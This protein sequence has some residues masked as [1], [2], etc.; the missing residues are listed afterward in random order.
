MKRM[1]AT[2]LLIFSLP[3]VAS[4]SIGGWGSPAGLSGKP[5]IPEQESYA[6]ITENPFVVARTTP[7]S[8][9]GIDVDTASYSNVRRFLQGHRLPPVEAVRIEEM[10][11]S[12]A[13]GYADPSDGR[14][15]ALHTELS[16]CPWNK[17]H[18]LL[19]VGL[20]AKHLQASQIPPRNLVFLLDVSGSMSG[21]DKLPLMKTAMKKVVDQLRPE[22]SVAIVT[23]ATD[24]IVRLAPRKVTDKGVILRC[25]DSLQASGS[26]NGSG[27]IQM[28]YQLAQKNFD[29]K[30]VNRVIL[31]TDGDFNVGVVSI[32]ALQ[33]LIAEKR[34]TG[35]FL[36]VVGLGTG[37]LK[38]AT[39]EMLADRGN[40]RY[41]YLDSS[42][43]ARKA[44]G[45]ELGAD[46]VTVAKDVKV[47]IEFNPA[48]VHSYRLIGYENRALQARDF[49]DDHK[50]AGE[51]GAGHSVTALY[52]IVRS[53]ESGVDALR[54]QPDKKPAQT[55][56]PHSGEVCLVKIRYKEPA[57]SV[58]QRM[59][60]IVE[61]SAR[62]PATRDMRF[63]S[64]VAGFGLLLRQS[65]HKGEADYKMIK[66]LAK[67]SLGPDE[68]GDR[69]EFV[70]LVE[71]AEDMPQS[72]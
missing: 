2:W 50:D 15:I 11:N 18:E 61:A 33:T 31:A 23:Y 56:V 72:Q 51:M 36:T 30:G 25:I 54:Y 21:R 7:L 47:Q 5:P 52:E 29:A 68:N 16:D 63:A 70:R 9:F 58:S 14:A 42:L 38:D 32:E 1:R 19:L 59:E 6:K 60:G 34:D 57:D 62:R 71:L 45:R 67:T 20:Q 53:R 37:N 26:T 40:G 3:C 43:E 4:C 35:V 69:H 8:T 46:L 41:V 55:E 27:G 66:E 10:I 44:F 64:A 65:A 13:Y 12:F 17:G 28:A 24:A 39:M 22:D 49:N 48:Q